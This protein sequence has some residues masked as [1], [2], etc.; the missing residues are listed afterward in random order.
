MELKTTLKV[1]ILV[2]VYFVASLLSADPVGDWYT[3]DDKTG[4]KKSKVYIG[5]GKSGKYYGVFKTLYKDDG[6]TVRTDK[7]LCDKCVKAKK[8]KPIIGM[9]FV[10]GGVLGEKTGWIM[11]PKNGK[12]YTLEM[13]EEGGTLKI[14]G[15]IG[16]FYRTQTWKKN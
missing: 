5:K 16:F 12:Y 9:Q 15:Y 3:Y 11:D 13:W 14:R 6:V 8:D 1:T 2:A 7:P 4:K 10:G